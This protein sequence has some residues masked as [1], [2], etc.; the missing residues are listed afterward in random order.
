MHFRLILFIIVLLPNSNYAQ[1]Y[2]E[3]FNSVYQKFKITP[4]NKEISKEDKTELQELEKLMD[5]L[6]SFTNQENKLNG[7]VHF[8]F[9]GDETEIRNLFTL[10]AGIN[11]DYGNYPYQLDFTTSIQTIVNN[12]VFQ[13]NVSNIDISFDYS[14]VNTGNGIWLENYILLKRFGDNYLGIN[15]RYETG[16]GFI[17]NYRSKS[18]TPKGEKIA[19]ELNRKPVLNSNGEDL[20]IC[21]EEI[22]KRS[23]NQKKLSREECETIGLTRKVYGNAN[24]KKYNKLRLALL[25]GAFYEIDQSIAQ[26][27]L[28]INGKDSLISATF[29]TQTFLR[30]ELRPTIE[31]RPNDILKIKL[32]PYI[33]F[34]LG[35]NNQVE[36]RYE[37]LV[38]RRDDYFIDLRTSIKAQVTS[39]ISFGMEYRYLYDN[40]PN[41]VFLTEGFATPQLLLAQQE[42]HIYMMKFGFNF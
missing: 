7:G 15:Q 5:F 34:P 24:R 41:R 13:E 37:D 32:H 26:N 33:K 23:N 3:S 27:N 35:S 4:I 12:G 42:H 9:S 22:C 30:W 28:M 1:G 36:V 40:A 21:Y 39:K 31:Y 17:F 20:I 18:L 25:L 19:V 14:H 8:G 11:L 6:N 10:N 38:D 16:M 2:Q 29:P